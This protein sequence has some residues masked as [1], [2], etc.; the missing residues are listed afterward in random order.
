MQARQATR[1]TH[2]AGAALACALFAAAPGAADDGFRCPGTNAAFFEELDAAGWVGFGEV[3]DMESCAQGQAYF[4]EG[5]RQWAAMRPQYSRLVAPKLNA[6]FYSTIFP[7]VAFG[8]LASIFV[9]SWLM[10]FIA[11]RRRVRMATLSCP[12]CHNELPVTL[13]DPALRSLFCPACGEACVL[14]HEGRRG[15]ARATGA[16]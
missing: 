3:W 15:P 1:G 14:V 9:L 7:V 6:E 16:A 13:D 5:A 2:L 10:A 12:S 4:T 8:G 11:R